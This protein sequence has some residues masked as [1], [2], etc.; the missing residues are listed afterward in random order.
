MFWL[1]LYV[2]V[3]VVSLGTL[4][5]GKTTAARVVAGAVFGFW[6]LLAV[7]TV[8]MTAKIAP[9]EASPT[10]KIASDAFTPN[11]AKDFADAVAKLGARRFEEANGLAPVAA[12]F[13]ATSE[14]CDRIVFVDVSYANSTPTALQWLVDC[15]N[16]HRFR[17]AEKALR[18]FMGADHS[19]PPNPEK[20]TAY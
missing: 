5:R 16:G 11:A 18:Q 3:G 19:A 10:S 12:A 6:L 13:V 15:Q 2:L 4:I 14:R 1:L 17:I 8:S 7:A 9:S 20:R